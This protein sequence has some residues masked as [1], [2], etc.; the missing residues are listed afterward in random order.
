MVNSRPCQGKSTRL[1]IVLAGAVLLSSPRAASAQFWAQI[2]T[3][4]NVT[5]VVQRF[6]LYPPSCEA[7]PCISACTNLL[8][9]SF[10]TASSG[11]STYINPL[12]MPARQSRYPFRSG[13]CATQRRLF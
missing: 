13:T 8:V 3:G 9:N 5:G 1:A 6:Y 4:T 10:S 11:F 2:A 7:D 12:V